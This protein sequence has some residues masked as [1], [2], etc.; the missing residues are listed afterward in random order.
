MI[1]TM[2]KVHSLNTIF[3]AAISVAIFSSC[4]DVAKAQNQP[5]A[6]SLIQ[7]WEKNELDSTKLLKLLLNISLYST[8]PSDR[9]RFANILY[10]ESIRLRRKYYEG[11]AL[12][13]MGVAYRFKGDLQKALREFFKSSKIASEN[14]YNVLLGKNYV[15]ISTAYTLNDDL[16]NSLNYNIKALALLRDKKRAQDIG[17]TL[18][19]IGYDFY[20]LKKFDSALLFYS[21]SEQIMD[22]V[23]LTIGLAYIKGNR[24]LVKW[25]LG[26]IGE[27]ISDLNEAISMLGPLGDNYGMADYYNQLGNIYLEQDS[28]EQ[29]VSHLSIGVRLAKGEDLKEQ[30]R[31]ASKLLSEIYGK[32]GESDSAYHYLNQYLAMRDSIQSEETTRELANQRADFEIGLKEEEVEKLEKERQQQLVIAIASGGL[33]IIL[34]FIGYRYQQ[35]RSRKKLEK[36]SI[37]KRLA[38][39]TALKAQI[40]PHFLFNALNSIQSYILEG[41]QD[42]AEDYLIKYGKLM[43]MILDHSNDLLV[44]LDEELRLLQLYIELEQ[45]R[46]DGGFDYQVD[47]DDVIDQ[48]RT[49][50]PSMVIQPFLENAIWHGVSKLGGKG[51]IQLH[52]QLDAS[53]ELIR[54]TVQDNGEGFDT[55]EPRKDTSKGVNLVKERLELLKETKNSASVI[56]IASEIRVGTKITLKLPLDLN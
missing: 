29:A 17:L 47:V 35:N 42:I 25:K 16:E 21:E 11:H 10:N 26:S 43:R 15:E 9:M 18:L 44:P 6:D 56:E 40:N 14:D 33:L 3:R 4:F 20:T 54:V 2:K 30:V 41:E 55:E 36:Q 27:A 1:L 53:E 39:L 51:I 13:Q 23:D 28:L 5:I 24:A 8:D 31:D 34:G 45:I 48:S 50:I 49:N 32:L 19:N 52:V 22:S 38:E 7:V 12:H 46:I 37:D